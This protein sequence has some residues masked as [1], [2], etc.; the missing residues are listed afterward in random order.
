MR[1]TGT[2]KKSKRLWLQFGASEA[3][4]ARRFPLFYEIRSYLGVAWKREN[5]GKR[6]ARSTKKNPVLVSEREAR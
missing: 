6:N 4:L 5:I 1:A 3:S 2:L